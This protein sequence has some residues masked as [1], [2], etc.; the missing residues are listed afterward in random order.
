MPC[1]VLL[2]AIVVALLLLASRLSTT[3]IEEH[4]RRQEDKR[5]EENAK[6]CRHVAKKTIDTLRVEMVRTFPPL[7]WIPL[8]TSI[9]FVPNACA[10]NT[11]LADCFVP[12]A[13]SVCF[14]ELPRTRDSIDSTIATMDYRSVCN[15]DDSQRIAEM[16][17]RIELVFKSVAE[18]KRLR[19]RCCGFFARAGECGIT[20]FHVG[21]R[22][23]NLSVADVNALFENEARALFGVSQAR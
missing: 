17:R 16:G 1:R 8:S 18:A 21:R 3:I 13:E 9:N 2:G 4:H 10:L 5:K 7:S 22:A 14:Q 12:P 11:F 20:P 6:E 23:K 19:A 15:S